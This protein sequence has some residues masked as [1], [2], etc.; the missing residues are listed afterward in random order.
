[1]TQTFRQKLLH[2]LSPIAG[3]LVYRYSKVSELFDVAKANKE[4]KKFIKIL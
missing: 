4:L 2:D 1:M 3:D